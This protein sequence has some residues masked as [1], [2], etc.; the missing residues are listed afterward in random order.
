MRPNPREEALLRTLRG[1]PELMERLEKL[2]AV[3]GEESGG[4]SIDAVEEMV[5]ERMR[6][7]GR[8]TLK[9]W[10]ERAEEQESQVQRQMQPRRR[11]RGK[12]NSAG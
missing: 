1:Q 9:A 4:S 8:V 11:L 2:V 3:V 6:E 5:V 10:I 7:V 12:K